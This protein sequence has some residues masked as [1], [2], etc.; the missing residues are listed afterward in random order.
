[1]YIFK[2][3]F[4]KEVTLQKNVEINALSYVSI[5][6]GNLTF[7]VLRHSF[8]NLLVSIVT[9]KE[10]PKPGDM[11]YNSIRIEEGFIKENDELLSTMINYAMASIYSG[12]SCNKDYVLLLDEN[13]A[14]GILQWI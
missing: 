4:Y 14:L 9:P 2:D 11:E 5:T 6:Q 3:P 1:M 10:F 8:K 13:R 12:V 7:Y